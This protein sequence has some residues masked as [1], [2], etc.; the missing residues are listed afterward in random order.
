MSRISGLLTRSCGPPSRRCWAKLGL[1]LGRATPMTRPRSWMTHWMRTRAI[2]TPAA[3]RTAIRMRFWSCQACWPPV[4][5]A[6][7]KGLLVTIVVSTTLKELK[8]P[9][10]RG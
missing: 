9:P 6:N 3:K 2:V 7:I 10:A 5:W 4:S 8:P 1:Q